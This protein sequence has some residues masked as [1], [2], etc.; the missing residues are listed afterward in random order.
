MYTSYFG[1]NENPFSI[2]PDPLYLYMSERH[3]EAMA[4]LQYGIKR[5]GGFVLLTGEVGAGKTTLCRS[6]LEQLPEGVDVAFVF[7]PKV[8]VIELLETICDELRIDRPEQGSVKKLVDRLNTYLL[9][10]NARGRKTVLFIDEAQNLSIDVLEQLR[11]LTNLET[12]RYKLLQI[13]LLGQPE[14]L[15][16]LGRQ[17][18][19]QFSQRVTARY[20]LGPLD[21]KEMGSYVHHRLAIAGSNRPLFPTTLNKTLWQLT[22]GIPRLIN[23]V[24]DRALLGAYSLDRQ[25]VDDG[26]LR[27]AAREVLGTLQPS[28][29]GKKAALTAGLVGLVLLLGIVTLWSWKR[30]SSIP[31]SPPLAAETK[32]SAQPQKQIEEESNPEVSVAS[33]ENTLKT[34]PTLW[35]NDFATAQ[36]M[37]SAFADL[38]GL[39][40][41]SYDADRSDYCSYAVAHGLECLVGKNSLDTLRNMNQPAILTLYDDDGDPFYVVLAGLAQDSALFLA[42]GKQHELALSAI[43]SRWFGEYLL[44][45]QRPTTERTLLKPGGTG[46]SVEWLAKTL[47]E[48]GLYEASGGEV[49]LEG[50]LLGALKRFQLSNGLTPDGV[51]GPMTLIHFNSARNLAGPRLSPPGTN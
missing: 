9:E 16:I 48:L 33:P 24:C 12:N 19:R 32:S 30:P 1:L 34:L 46:A 29:K 15:S 25:Q 31:V 38:A 37:K 20:H 39:W 7:N 3:R 51:L 11:L 8:S 50:A 36:S 35:P 47:Q 26:I 2:A 13:V 43:A 42:G 44:L 22:G 41:L 49:R 40:G 10:A 18:M 14:L 17:E 6:L 21:A 27:Q 45:W 28:G 4:H 5:D 23:L